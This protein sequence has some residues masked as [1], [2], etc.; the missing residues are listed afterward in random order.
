MQYIQIDDNKYIEFNEEN[1]KSNIIFKSDIQNELANLIDQI[2]ALPQ[3]PSDEELLSWAKMNYINT[4][5]RNRTV[6]RTTID[7]LTNKL[8]NL[9][10]NNQ[11]LMTVIKQ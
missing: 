4:D 7:D 11:T 1:N 8:S 2:N 6:L 5:A 9:E 3:M 10:G